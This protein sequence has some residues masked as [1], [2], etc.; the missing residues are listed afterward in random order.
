MITK[1]T[2]HSQQYRYEL[3][4][5]SPIRNNNTEFYTAFNKS[6]FQKYIEDMLR[7]LGS[8]KAIRFEIDI[9]KE[10]H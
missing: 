2:H 4:V 5:I 6:D 8:G 3:H 1:R 7:V 10:D 9:K